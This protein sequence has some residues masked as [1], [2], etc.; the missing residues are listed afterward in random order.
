MQLFSL[1]LHRAMR[2]VYCTGRDVFLHNPKGKLLLNSAYKTNMLSFPFLHYC[3]VFT[4]VSKA[5]Q[6]HNANLK[7]RCYISQEKH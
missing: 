3:N 2:R 5:K 1:E 4:E 7:I 6:T